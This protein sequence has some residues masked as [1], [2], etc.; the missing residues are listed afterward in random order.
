ME[1]KF[2]SLQ[3]L[4][5]LSSADLISLA[6]D[7]GI[8]VPD[9]LNRRFIIGELLEVAQELSMDEKSENQEMIEGDGAISDDEVLPSS[10]NETQISVVLRNP[11]WAFAYWDISEAAMRKIQESE[12]FSGLVLRTSYFDSEESNSPVSSFDVNLEIT[13]R[14][15]YVLLETGRKFMRIDL[16]AVFKNGTSDNLCISRK[17]E[18]PEVPEIFGKALHGLDVEIPEI[19]EVSG[20]RKLLKSHY[21]KYRESFSK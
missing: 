4:E 16:V 2:L 19:L 13:D 14:E 11:A 8:D 9:D 15:Q 20:L 1:T 10:F 12:K 6:D 21:E 17:I 3:Y 7:Y 5:T 18:L